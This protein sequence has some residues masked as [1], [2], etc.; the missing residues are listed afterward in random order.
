M[1]KKEKLNYF[2]SRY[3]E[4]KRDREALAQKTQAIEGEFSEWLQGFG[5]PKSGDMIDLL[6]AFNKDKDTDLVLPS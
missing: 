4:L 6:I 5:A 1:R 2:R 3:D